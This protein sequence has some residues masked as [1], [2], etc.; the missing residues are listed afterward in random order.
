MR[1]KM[2]S[3]CVCYIYFYKMFRIKQLKSRNWI[4]TFCFRTNSDDGEVN[5]ISIHWA[6]MLLT[7]YGVVCDHKYKT[8]FRIKTAN[9]W[10]VSPSL[11]ETE[12]MAQITQKRSVLIFISVNEV[13]SGRFVRG[14]LKS[15]MPKIEV[16]PSHEHHQ[17]NTKWQNCFLQ[18][19]LPSLGSL[20]ILYWFLRR[21]K[22]W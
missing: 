18:V 21:E 2:S 3:K 22:C 9:S 10:L 16:T 6:G 8:G 5:I 4:K 19:F 17:S 12:H 7:D 20:G 11:S 14:W 15:Y 13:I 1:I